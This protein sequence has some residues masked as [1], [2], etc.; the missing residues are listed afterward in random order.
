MFACL[1]VV[2]VAVVVFILFFG[3]F[4]DHFA[5]SSCLILVEVD[6][7]LLALMN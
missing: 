7:L 5:F 3:S 2:V 4:S 6:E 1:F